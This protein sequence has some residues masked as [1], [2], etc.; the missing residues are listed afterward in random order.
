[1]KPAKKALEF[2]LSL[3]EE[4]LVEAA[5]SLGM[6]EL[7]YLERALIARA[8]AVKEFNKVKEDFN[9]RYQTLT[10]QIESVCDHQWGETEN[11][12]NDHD[13]WS[14]VKITYYH[15]RTCTVC[16]KKEEFTST[17]DY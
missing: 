13:G 7:T 5:A 1:M 10:Y 8:E 9:H 6:P 12:G 11:H 3:D 4:K 16:G 15:S 14:R 17:S 2:L